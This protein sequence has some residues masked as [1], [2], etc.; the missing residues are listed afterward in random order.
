MGDTR[1]SLVNTRIALADAPA[2]A[3]KSYRRLIA[4]GAIEAQVRDDVPFSLGLVFPVCRNFGDFDAAI[5]A[6]YRRCVFGV[7]IEVTGH[8]WLN[9]HDGFAALIKSDKGGNGL[10][11][12]FEGSFDVACPN[13]KRTVRL[14]DEGS[15]FIGEGLTIWCT[16]P[17]TA[18][19]KC[20]ACRRESPIRDWR[21]N[22][23]TFAAGHLGFT[24]WGAYLP[25]LFE[26]RPNPVGTKIRYLIG[27]DAEDYAPVFCHI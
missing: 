14:G 3:L 13:C 17:E 22:T 8:V 24:L 25:P 26:E 10:F 16:Q 1:T 9:G 20:P 21:S 18:A 11:F 19:M 6:E 5:G 2:V 27:D 4:A 15:D 23:N 7:E 12:N